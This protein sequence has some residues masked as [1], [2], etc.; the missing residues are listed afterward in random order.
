MSNNQQQL[1]QR[2]LDY[3][4]EQ[5]ISQGV[6][7]V[8]VDDIAAALAISK[9]T[10]YAMFCDKEQLLLESIK[11]Q[12]DRSNREMEQVISDSANPLEGYMKVLNLK[13][14]ELQKVSPLFF[15]EIGK[16]E[17]CIRLFEGE[18]IRRQ[19][20]T[21]EF[22]EKCVAEGLF[23]PD[24]NYKLITQITDIIGTALNENCLYEKYPFED[25]IH[26]IHLTLIRGI[27]TTKG[28]E[29]INAIYHK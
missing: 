27:C 4:M 25:I 2:I 17:S 16:Y 6:K 20:H 24:I 18:R 3:S 19:M 14:K 9:R 12:I 10:L 13:T 5:F 7:N 1:R 23:L 11:A 26:S 8:K 15:K 28:L 22:I 29:V 21:L